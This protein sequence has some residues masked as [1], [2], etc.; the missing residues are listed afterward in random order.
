M[1]GR[2]DR[3]IFGVR[4]LLPMNFAS[5]VERNGDRVVVNRGSAHGVTTGSTYHVYS[6]GTKRV[7]SAADPA[8]L[9]RLGAIEIESV[10][11]VRSVARITAEAPPDAVAPRTRAFEISHARGAMAM[12][13]DIVGAGQG[14][15]ST[16]AALRDAL[17][18]SPLVDVSAA[19]SAAAPFARA[20]LIAPRAS[21]GPTDPAPQLGAVDRPTWAVVDT[22]GQLL[23]P[24]RYPGEESI[25]RGNLEK[26]VRYRQ[27]LAL[28]NPNPNSALRGKFA[29]EV[30]RWDASGQ[31]VVATPD[32]RRGL[33]VLENGEPI[34]FRVTST[35]DAPAYISVLDFQENHALSL[36]FPTDGGQDTFHPGSPFEKGA[37]PPGSRE[38]MK[39][40]GEFRDGALEATEALKLFVTSSPA[41]FGVLAQTGTR[42]VPSTRAA[43]SPVTTLLRIAVAT[44]DRS[45]ATL[46]RAIVADDLPEDDPDDWTA[47]TAS[48][49]IRRTPVAIDGEEKP[50]DGRTTLRANGFAAVVS[51]SAGSNAAADE[52]VDAIQRALGETD[53][54]ATKRIEVAD[55][56]R[57]E[58]TRDGAG[59]SLHLMVPRGDSGEQMIVSTDA[60]GVVTLHFPQPD[61]ATRALGGPAA[62]LKF[63]IPVPTVGEAPA[64][65]TRGAIDA[66]M[67]FSQSQIGR[68]VLT[69]IVYPM[70]GAAL[71]SVG[72]DMTQ[73]WET[74]ARPYRA[75][76]FSPDN[77][78]RGDVPS[79]D[80]EGWRH[81]SGGR[82]LLFLHDTFGRAHAG[83]AAMPRDF[84]AEL[85]RLYEG[86]V[87]A[88]DH[89]TLSHDPRRNAATLLDLLTRT[90]DASLDVDVLAHGR[91]ALVARAL[92]EGG[93][94][95]LA[96]IDRVR[97]RNVVMAGAPNA[98]TPFGDLVN[99]ERAITAYTVLASSILS[100][101]ADRS[102]EVS[103]PSRRR[104]CSSR[105]PGSRASA[106]CDQGATSS[107]RSSR[108]TPRRRRAW[109]RA[110]S[111]SLPTSCRRSPA[112][113]GGFETFSPTR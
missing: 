66:A 76:A 17:S 50:I 51:N 72:E 9:A 67:V 112:S 75:R 101:S 55:A 40:Q 88:F 65:G 21:V 38:R 69:L 30:M 5:V 33:P 89:F 84:V 26:V 110:T 52:V 2:V 104:F 48:F 85:D 60:D 15:E 46:T 53:G 32:E 10:S 94:S 107:I 93:S 37:V 71:A 20:Y 4:E 39:V 1:E 70:G 63:R 73:R 28:E 105:R 111:P 35:H 64:P 8:N 91:G 82:S 109:R 99:I 108:G 22:T 86:R 19:A 41:N 102:P 57:T 47:V 77:Y 13:V 78:A 18:S 97:V 29:I 43:D 42:A 96:G 3:D 45:G 79:L 16:V 31:W 61:G 12:S 80:V 14:S 87:F 27:A 56:R 23:M 49:V 24:R 34:A 36:L 44:D 11:V 113:R 6:Q 68:Q 92:V 62:P 83:F 103:S 106:P 81:L 98:G 59:P 95:T 90:S 100:N 54:V 58:G 74:A 7:P 25:I